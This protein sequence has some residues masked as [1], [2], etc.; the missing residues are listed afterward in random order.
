MSKLYRSNDDIVLA[1]VF[2]GI[3]EYLKINS[4]ILRVAFIIF[5]LYNGSLF[6]MTVLYGLAVLMIPKL[7]AN[8]FEANY[9]YS[10]TQGKHNGN[11][12]S[13]RNFKETFKDFGA[14]VK[15]KSESDFMDKN[16]SLLGYIMIAFGTYF[17]LDKIFYSLRFNGSIIPL[18]L[19]VLGLFVL[20]RN[21]RRN[22]NEK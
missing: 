19:I 17:A 11:T 1:G 16:K 2:G 8:E 12:F 5:A 4:D 3:G 6:M 21:D 18:V 13:S 22:G 14:E 20:F 9:T 7:P 10:D 15:S